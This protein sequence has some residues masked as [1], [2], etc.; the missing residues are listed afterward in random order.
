MDIQDETV[1]LSQNQIADLFQR[2]KSVISRH[3]K[4]IFENEELD[5]N[6]TVAFFATVQNED[7]RMVKRNIEYFNLYVILSPVARESFFF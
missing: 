1:C 4:N 6:S 5:K 3:I 2:D 7:G